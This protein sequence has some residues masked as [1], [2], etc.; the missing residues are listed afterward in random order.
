MKLVLVYGFEYK[1]IIPN[2]SLL[3]CKSITSKYPIYGSVVI[4][5][6]KMDNLLSLIKNVKNRHSYK[7]KEANSY[8]I[9]RNIDPKWQLALFEDDI[10]FDIPDETNTERW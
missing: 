10:S 8:T 5:E 3:K 4:F 2:C 9:C 6:E 1:Y 7:L